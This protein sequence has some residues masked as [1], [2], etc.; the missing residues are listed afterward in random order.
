MREKSTSF[1]ILMLLISM[2]FFSGVGTA[3]IKNIMINHVDVV[4]ENNPSA[5]GVI[6]KTANITSLQNLVTVVITSPEDGAIVTDPHL[7]VLGYAIDEAGMNYWE[8]EWHYKGGSHSNSSYFETAEYVEFRIDIYGLQP[9]WNLVIVRFKNIY[10]VYGEDSVNVTYTPPNN[11]PNKP[12][13]PEGPTTGKVKETLYYS[14]VTT[15]PDEDSLEYLIDWG[16]GTDT[17]WLGPITSGTPF[18]NFHSW[19]EP[20][21]YQIKAKARDIPSYEESE[22]SDPLTVTITL[23]MTIPGISFNQVDYVFEDGNKCTDSYIGQILVDEEVLTSYFGISTGYLNVMTPLGWV[24][25]NLLVTSE[26]V[27]E[28]IP[29]VSCKFHLREGA[30]CGIDVDIIDAYV[31]FSPTPTPEFYGELFV[32]YPVASTTCYLE[33]SYF[34][35]EIYQVI[36]FPCF[37]TIPCLQD[38]HPNI[39][40]ANNQCGPAA[41]ANSLQYL[42]NKYPDK[43]KIPHDNR[44][45][46]KGDTTLVGQLDTAMDRGVINRKNGQTVGDLQYIEGKLRYLDQNKLGQ[47]IKVKHQAIYVENDVTVGNLTSKSKGK[48]VTFDFIFDEICAGEDVE[49][50]LGYP[51]GGGHWVEVTGA[52]YICGRPF[53]RHVSDLEQTDVDPTDTKGCDITYTDYIVQDGNVLRVVK[54]D[55]PV[56]TTIEIVV[57]QSPNNPPNKPNKPNGPTKGKPGKPYTYNTAAPTDPDGD[58][59]EKYEWDLDGDGKVDKTTSSPSVTH[60]WSEQGTYKI[61]VR[62]RDEY[63]A[64]SEWSDPLTVAISK[65]RSNQFSWLQNVFQRK[66]KILNFQMDHMLLKLL[67]Q[68]NKLLVNEQGS[69]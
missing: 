19:D 20:G 51:G 24:V 43:I 36:N 48:K 41:V 33:G 59:V 62:A 52:G 49:I 17:G 3:Q 28:G 53:I 23:D 38:N 57:S 60:S 42:E 32:T 56:D 31:D 5:V 40:A 37:P 66:F 50:G 16:D 55:S 22:W 58:K 10:E 63:G 11:P 69:K 26:V 29:Y 13:K 61:K 4:K 25:Q 1:L 35:P 9:G 34:V 15:D 18:E 44:L 39:Q 64:V 46:L 8:W 14:T 27:N 54:G 6:T 2:A 45:G 47:C 7:V 30:P 68:I 12:T 65:A 67:M 21:T